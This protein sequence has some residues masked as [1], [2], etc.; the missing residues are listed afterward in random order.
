MR[1]PT[2]A[3]PILRFSSNQTVRWKPVIC[4]FRLLAKIRPIFGG[5]FVVMTLMGCHL[6]DMLKVMSLPKHWF[7]TSSVSYTNHDS[8]RGNYWINHT[9]DPVRWVASLRY[10]LWLLGV[11][12][13]KVCKDSFV[14]KELRSNIWTT[15]QHPIW[16]CLRS[17]E[18]VQHLPHMEICGIENDKSTQNKSNTLGTYLPTKHQEHMSQTSLWFAVAMSSATP[19]KNTLL[20]KMLRDAPVCHC[21]TCGADLGGAGPK[22]AE[23]TLSQIRLVGGFN[24]FGKY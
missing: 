16:I 1:Q 9:S 15:I 13:P 18:R 5:F 23:V 22:N 19:K 20:T 8:G 10:H 24:P 7:K 6:Q 4:L 12:R 14:L 17:S 2:V 21:Y 3:K 11:R